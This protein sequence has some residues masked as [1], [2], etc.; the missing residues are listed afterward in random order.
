MVIIG[1]FFP[2]MLRLLGCSRRG[3]L[4]SGLGTLFLMS[5]NSDV[6]IIAPWSMWNM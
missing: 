6:V 2:F 4:I 1:E 5:G 3:R